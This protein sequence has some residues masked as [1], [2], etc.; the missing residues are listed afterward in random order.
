MQKTKED[1]KVT[2]TLTNIVPWSRLEMGRNDGSSGEETVPVNVKARAPVRGYD[3]RQMSLETLEGILRQRL[4]MPISL[5]AGQCQKQSGKA[6]P[7][8]QFYNGDFRFATLYNRGHRAP[9][10]S[11]YILRGRG[12]PA[13][14][15]T[16]YYEPQLAN[17]KGEQSMK[18]FPVNDQNVMESQAMDDD[19]TAAPLH[20]RGHLSSF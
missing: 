10:Y 13:G 16:W 5:F 17:S 7:I 15:E 9:L 12:Q 11:A 20:T 1:S 14:R 6:L 19:Y 3:V 2:F 4:A 18:P 8:C